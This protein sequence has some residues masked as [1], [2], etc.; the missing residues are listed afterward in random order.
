[1]EVGRQRKSDIFMNAFIIV[2]VY[3]FVTD[4]PKKKKRMEHHW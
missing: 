4:C 3:A 1:M 2:Y